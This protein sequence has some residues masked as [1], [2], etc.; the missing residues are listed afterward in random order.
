MQ[1]HLPSRLDFKPCIPQ[2][3][4]CKGVAVM[5]IKSAAILSKKKS[6]VTITKFCNSG[7]MGFSFYLDDF[8]ISIRRQSHK[9]RLDAHSGGN[10]QDRVDE[11]KNL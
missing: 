6:F 4:K 9:G 10:G 11:V 3:Q 2:V 1:S 8:G 7:I 5:R